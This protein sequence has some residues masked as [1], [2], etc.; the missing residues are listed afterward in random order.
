MKKSRINTK[1]KVFSLSREK[2]TPEN[3]KESIKRLYSLVEEINL[4]IPRIDLTKYIFKSIHLS[5][6]QIN[7]IEESNYTNI[8][9][10]RCAYTGFFCILGELIGVK[11]NLK[12]I[13]KYPDTV[14]NIN[15]ICNKFVPVSGYYTL[16]EDFEGD[17]VL[18]EVIQK[19]NKN[20]VTLFC[21]DEKFKKIEKYCKKNC[22]CAKN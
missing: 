18:Y 6:N 10:F 14:I 5:I 15:L 13:N 11:E 22:I 20:S 4:T 8:G 7:L 21:S 12:E 17:P 2:L 1:L 16:S 9:A 19:K 3:Q